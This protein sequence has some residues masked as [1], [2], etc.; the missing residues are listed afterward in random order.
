MHAARAA[1]AEVIGIDRIGELGRERLE[2]IR[3]RIQDDEDG[4]DE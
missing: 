1:L 4:V 2:E 3:R